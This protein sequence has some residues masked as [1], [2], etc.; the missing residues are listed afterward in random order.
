VENVARLLLG[1]VTKCGTHSRLFAGGDKQQIRG[2]HR[3]C[4]SWN[5]AEFVL[6]G[7]KSG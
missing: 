1:T 2:I 6:A 7:G 4:K 5:I 3:A